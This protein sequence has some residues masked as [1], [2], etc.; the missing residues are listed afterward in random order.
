MLDS[1]S[2]PYGNGIGLAPNAV[3]IRELEQIS[4]RLEDDDVMEDPEYLKWISMLI[5]PGASLGGARPK[6]SVIDNDGG[7]WIAKFPSRNDQGDIGGWEIVTYQ[8][9]IA[10]GIN[11]AESKAQKFSSNYYTFLTKR[12]D[13]LLSGERIHFA[14]AMTMLGYTDGQDH[15]DG[16]SYLELVEFIQN[17]GA[18]VNRDLEEL[19]RRIVFSICVTNTDDHLRNHGFILTEKGWVLSPAYDIN[20]VETGTG[21]KLNI[22]D[23]DNSLDLDLALEVSEFFRLSEKKASD[24]IKEVKRAV[25]EWKKVAT[26]YGISRQ[27]QELKSLAFKTS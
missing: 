9:A 24:I 25:G 14:S 3:S 15:S 13:R 20:P 26:K 11:M 22:S 27:E 1:V 12:F 19:W 4:L 17:Y 6:A 8:L 23:D 21:L 10:A 7:L 2:F 5:A 16:A 18:N